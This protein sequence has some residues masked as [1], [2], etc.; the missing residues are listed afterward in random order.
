MSFSVASGSSADELYISDGTWGFYDPSAKISNF[1][2]APQGAYSTEFGALFLERSVAFSGATPGTTS[3]D[4][5][6]VFRYLSAGRSAVDLS[7]NGLEYLVHRIRSRYFPN[8]SGQIL[9]CWMGSIP[10]CT[11]YAF[12]FGAHLHRRFEQLHPC[13]WRRIECERCANVG[14]PLLGQQ[15]FASKREPKSKQCPICRRHFGCQ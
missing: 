6:S 1:T 15:P 9:H 14:I 4:Y 7:K 13:S 3:E 12:D 10:F 5:I 8:R 2:V 11:H